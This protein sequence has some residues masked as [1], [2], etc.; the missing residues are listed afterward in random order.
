MIYYR[1]YRDSIVKNLA[2]IKNRVKVPVTAV[3]KANAYG[4][5]LEKISLLLYELGCDFAVANNNECSQILSFIPNAKV[6]VLGNELYENY[7]CN[8]VYSV[9]G[10]DEIDFI[11]GK[12]KRV[13]IKVNTGMNRFGC[14]IS[15]VESLVNYAKLKGLSVSE[16]YTHFSSP[17]SAKE[18]FDLFVQGTDFC[19]GKI[20]RHCCCSNCMS[21]EQQYYL[22]GV[23]IGLALYGFGYRELTPSLEIYLKIVNVLSLNKGD[24]VGYGDLTLVKDAKIA[25]LSAGYADGIPF[26][27]NFTVSINGKLCK[28]VNRPCMDSLAVDV[29]DVK[30]CVGDSAYILG[31]GISMNDACSFCDF[32]P[33]LVLTAFHT[34]VIV[35]YV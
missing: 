24:K 12:T 9:S 14:A 22:D 15:S 27:K 31:G 20:K 5:G 18:Q 33:H 7:N 19:N 30:C 13:A 6:L 23:R 21:L 26:S 11:K 8:A 17:C 28:I 10:Y 32:I 4:L 25:I 35:D 34:R 3:V 2:K 29:T 16:I 1:V